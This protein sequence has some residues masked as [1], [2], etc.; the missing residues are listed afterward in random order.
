[1]SIFKNYIKINL[2]PTLLFTDFLEW[3]SVGS[4]M[5]NAAL[6]GTI[7]L[8]IASRLKSEIGGFYIAG[9]FTV[10]GFSFL[11]VTVY[12][13]L[14]IFLGVMLYAKTKKVPFKNLLILA[15][16]SVGISPVVS[17]IS[18][19]G[20]FPIYVSIPLGFIVGLLI[21]FI[22]PPFS[23]NTKKFHK[24]YNLYNTGFAIGIIGT[25]IN[26]FLKSFNII[27]EPIS[28]MCQANIP[29]IVGFLVVSCIYFIVV[30]LIID[31]DALKNNLKL[32]KYSGIPDTDF[33]KIEGFASSFV[34]MGLLGLICVLFVLGLGGYLN[35]AAIAGMYS[36]VGFA[37]YG[38]NARNILPIMLGVALAG[39]ATNTPLSSSSVIVAALFATAVAPITGEFGLLAGVVAGFLHLTLTKNTIFMH[40]GMNLFNN[41]FALGLIVVIMLPILEMIK[42]NRLKK[43]SIE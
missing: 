12:S 38:K 17:Q 11:G 14:P 1:M 7:C 41:G 29:I 4:A 26:S 3:G 13:S 30:G 40:G 28:L 2:S 43:Q 22:L 24:G 37:A 15:M 39:L 36:V 20:Y 16:F 35:G 21:G 27:V 18:F 9:F 33:T 34:N 5:L 6:N 42:E 10:V 25:F 8:L 32:Q 31:K 19:K 23:A